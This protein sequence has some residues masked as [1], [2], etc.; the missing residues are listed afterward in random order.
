MQAQLA[1]PQEPPLNS[2]LSHPTGSQWSGVHTTLQRSHFTRQRDFAIPTGLRGGIGLMGKA[3]RKKKKEVGAAQAEERRCRV[4]VASSDSIWFQRH[5][6]VQDVTQHN[7][8]QGGE[9]SSVLD[10]NPW[11]VT[12]GRGGHEGQ[13]EEWGGGGG[14]SKGC[15]VWGVLLSSP[16]HSVNFESHTSQGQNSL[17]C[18][19]NT[20]LWVG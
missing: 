19:A 13:G 9:F 3:V 17:L 7:L 12:G 14:G 4:S 1:S 16:F 15:P 2:P 20:Q 5:F 8:A 18:P 6:R 11:G 10:R